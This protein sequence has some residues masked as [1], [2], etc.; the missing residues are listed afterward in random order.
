[1]ANEI[2]LKSVL[3]A[4]SASKVSPAGVLA[5]YRE[6]ILANVPEAQE[7]Y[8]KIDAKEIFPTNALAMLR[9]IVHDTFVKAGGFKAEQK[10]IKA[11]ERAAKAEAEEAEAHNNS[12]SKTKKEKWIASIFD[13]KGQVVK[14]WKTKKK[15]TKFTNA[16]GEKDES[17]SYERIQ[18]ELTEKFD[19]PQRADEWV[20][21]RLVTGAGEDTVLD[22]DCFGE[23]WKTS[24]LDREGMV[25]V[26]T[27]DMRQAR[28]MLNPPVKK[29]AAHVKKP[30]TKGGG[31]SLS[32]A[33]CK[34]FVARFSGC[35]CALPILDSNHP[36]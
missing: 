14:V 3:S 7:V 20:A 27:I 24:H 23:V 29:G 36:R 5:T 33:N 32:F 30:S 19:L 35:L 10:R 9:P 11:E 18:V 28:A 15:V 25:M 8:S 31:A 26:T 22:N 21:R 13:S 1:M 6:F 16:E 2:T 17:I 4:M 34:S 12:T